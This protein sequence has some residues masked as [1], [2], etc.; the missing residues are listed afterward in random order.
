MGR[1]VAERL[2]V[3]SMSF[4]RLGS[5]LV[6]VAAFVLVCLKFN[7]PDGW[8]AFAASLLAI[9]GLYVGFRRGRIVIAILVG[10]PDS[11][12]IVHNAGTQPVSNLL[13]LCPKVLAN[14]QRDFNDLPS[15]LEGG[16]SRRILVGLGGGSSPQYEFQ[17]IWRTPLLGKR[18]RKITTRLVPP[19]HQRVQ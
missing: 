9:G 7:N 5:I 4:I 6:A 18:T 15:R 10:R 17:V 8:L 2:N 3:N 13:I 19:A 1:F 14:F 16:D 12:F 11:Y